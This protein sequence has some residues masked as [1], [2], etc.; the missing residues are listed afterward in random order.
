MDHA[1]A[2]IPLPE[3]PCKPRPHGQTMM[4][5]WGL[6]Y[7]HL[8]D[9]MESQGFLVDEAKFVASSAR[10]MP[11]DLLVKKNKAYQD[12]GIFTFP[13]GQFT[14][15]CL[16]QGN[17]GPFLDE[18]VALGFSGIE[19][20]DNLLEISL[21]DKTA[22]IRKAVAHGLTVVGEVGRKE[23]GMTGDEIIADCEA[24]LEAGCKLV[25]LE[26]HELFHGGIRAD[27]IEVLMGRIPSERIMF[28]LPVTALPDVS[29]HYK[30]RILSWLVA[31]FGTN[32][33]LANVEW[34]E[35]YFAEMTRVGAC[36]D[37]A[38]KDGAYGRAGI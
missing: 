36:G 22:A 29:R 9:L 8:L 24:C 16:A 11:R 10:I 37:N 34:D 28:E 30:I 25:L 3:R 6:S 26:A 4:I 31:N 12:N 13:G 7:N 23:G 1:F 19:V 35:V 17:Y 15:L 38:H 32:V 2:G 33:N 18:V 14:E 21:A 20:S 5:D 27:V